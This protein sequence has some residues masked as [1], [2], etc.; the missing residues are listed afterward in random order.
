[1][2]VFRCDQQLKGLDLPGYNSNLAKKLASFGSQ[3]SGMIGTGFGSWTWQLDPRL[4][5]AS[6][7]SHVR[8]TVCWRRPP[9]SNWSQV[10]VP[11]IV[12]ARAAS[13]LDSA[14]PWAENGRGFTI[15]PWGFKRC[16][17]G[18][19]HEFGGFNFTNGSNGRIS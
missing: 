14:R 3:R 10:P 16:A 19:Q 13:A 9:A 12:Q 17:W 18:F 2:L 7:D 11:A 5:E 4:I 8:G 1:M 6:V 15:K